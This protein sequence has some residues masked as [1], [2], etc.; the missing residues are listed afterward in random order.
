MHD[1]AEL[2]VKFVIGWFEFLRICTEEK[3]LDL[4]ENASVKSLKIAH[5]DLQE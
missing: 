5:F 4:I 2:N 3:L 1:D